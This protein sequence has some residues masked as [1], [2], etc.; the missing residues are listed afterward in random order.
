MEVINIKEFVKSWENLDKVIFKSVSTASYNL[1]DWELRFLEAG[2][3]P[4]KIPFNYHNWT[5]INSWCRKVFGE[6]HY[7]WYD[8]VFWFESE[9]DAALF[10][11]KWS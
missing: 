3:H 8:S 6:Q 4:A 1:P 11:L 7:A 2:Y 5:A 9:H 10:L